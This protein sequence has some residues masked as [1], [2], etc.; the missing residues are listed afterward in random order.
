MS[1]ISRQHALRYHR[2]HSSRNRCSS[3]HNSKTRTRNMG[4]CWYY[5]KFGTN[6]KMYRKPCAFLTLN[7]ENIQTQYYTRLNATF[8]RQVNRL[9]LHQ[10]D[11]ARQNTKLLRKNFSTFLQLGIIRFYKKNQWSSLLQMVSKADSLVWCPC[12][13]F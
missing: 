13:D 7:Q 3:R 2:Q 6:A 12:G 1:F 5:H 9:I 10:R 11:S 8:K 4:I